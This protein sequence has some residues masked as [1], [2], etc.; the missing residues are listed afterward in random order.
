MLLTVSQRL[1]EKALMHKST[2]NTAFSS[3]PPMM[4][5]AVDDYTAALKCLPD[6]VKQTTLTQ[7][8]PRLP[9]VGGIEEIT[10]VEAVHIQLEADK[11]AGANGDVAAEERLQVEDDIRGCAKACWGNLGACYT[12]LVS[13]LAARVVRSLD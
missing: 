8:T 3:K 13:A 12:A 2:G 9:A 10:E 11:T 4:D 6:V 5:K 7:P 1:L